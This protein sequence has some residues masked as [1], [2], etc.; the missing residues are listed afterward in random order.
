MLQSASSPPATTPKDPGKDLPPKGQAK[1]QERWD[2]YRTLAEPLRLRL[3]ALVADEE[4][5]VGELAELL[6]ESQPNVS[7]AWTPLRDAGLVAA[8]RDGTRVF[9]R[10]RE[11]AAEDAVVLDAL[12]SG[13]AL[14]EK[15]GSLAR[16]SQVVAARDLAA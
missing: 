4:L 9:V 16:V 7:R 8:R 6:Q 13:R 10:L 5:A 15:D 1:T 2:L 12:T 14:V 3:L 11:G